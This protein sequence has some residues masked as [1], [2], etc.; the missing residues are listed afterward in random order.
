[1]AAEESGS[2]AVA[3][4]PI[5]FV[6]A[7]LVVAVP[8]Y[9]TFMPPVPGTSGW[10]TRVLIMTVWL[11]ILIFA[12]FIAST[13]D[14]WVDRVAVWALGARTT[15]REAAARDILRRLLSPVD[16][17]AEGYTWA[18]YVTDTRDSQLL[19]PLPQ[20]G[21]Q[22]AGRW[23]VGTGVTGT[24]YASKRVQIGQDG[25]L[26]PGGRFEPQ[27]GQSPHLQ[28]YR[29]VVAQPIMNASR[30]VIGVLTAA[31]TTDRREL[32]SE[33]GRRLHALLANDISRVLIDMLN[34]EE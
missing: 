2:N 6:G 7:I 28:E 27:P 12:V 21:N 34:Y 24:A 11:L 20:L 31:T 32:L 26:K 16:D 9:F 14:I 15:F 25:D 1:L 13:H 30:K 23:R 29:T 17:V 10:P 33:D 22:E 18:L 3:K 5:R 8:T 4:R 19:I